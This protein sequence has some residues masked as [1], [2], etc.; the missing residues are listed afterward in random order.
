ML[1]KKS[2]LR[3]LLLCLLSLRR[4]VYSIY[5]YATDGLTARQ[6]CSRRIQQPAGSP[7]D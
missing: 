7:K 2:F 6:I 5:M 4:Y 3:R 1:L